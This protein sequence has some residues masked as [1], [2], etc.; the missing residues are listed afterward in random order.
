MNPEPELLPP[1]PS[2]V[3]T[4]TAIPARVGQGPQATLGYWRRSW[5]QF[6]DNRAGVVSAIVLGVIV[7]VAL[8]GPQVADL[9]GRSPAKQ[10]LLHALDS[11]TLKYP[12]GTDELGRDIL[13]RAVYGTRVSLT[14]A[15]LTVTIAFTMGAFIGLISGFY[16]GRVDA[17]LMR[18]VDVLLS[19]PPLL[20]FIMLAVLFRPD[21]VSLAW[22]IASIGWLTVARLV[23]SE[24]M[25][26]KNLDFIMASRALG[27]RD[28]R[29]IVRHLIPATLPVM[30]VAASIAVGSTILTE[31]ALGYLGLGIQP[32]TATLGNMISDAQFFMSRSI[33]PILFPG[34]I[35]FTTVLSVT[36]V[37]NALRDALD[38]RLYR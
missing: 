36:L 25:S 27:A 34:M 11:P 2:V 13:T 24:A 8:A 23:R 12:F 5:L 28:R 20:F 33:Y 7:L 22:I 4:A 26:V 6:R 35:L 32:P 14:V 1:E 16:G 10:D 18:L 30:L 17:L 3:T 38:P 37:G 21:V 19:I 31:A 9:L 29:I 15:G